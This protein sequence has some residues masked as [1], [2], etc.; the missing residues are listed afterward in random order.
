MIAASRD[1]SLLAASLSR[2]VVL[3]R[4]SAGGAGAGIA[5]DRL[6]LTNRHVVTRGEPVV[7]LEDGTE[8]EARIEIVDEARDLALLRA[9]GPD[10]FPPI[11]LPRAAAGAVRV[12]EPV[13]AIGHPWG[14]RGVV[15]IGV[16]SGFVRADS[17]AGPI[18]LIRTDAVL[19]PGNSGGPLANLRGELV[20]VN[21]M[22]AARGQGLAIP[23]WEAE[24]LLSRARSVR[25]AQPAPAEERIV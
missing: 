2:G 14:S 15:T 22:V 1:L 18:T 24:R 19:A 8:M 10:G 3:V 5:W 17:A 13:V 21:T 9:A 4:T 25:A 12:G 23:V 16:V 7:I 20:G 11:A 6:V